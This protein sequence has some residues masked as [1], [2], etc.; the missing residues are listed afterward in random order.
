MQMR[1]YLEFLVPLFIL[2][3]LIFWFLTRPSYLAADQTSQLESG[4]PVAGEQVYWAGGCGSCHA[5]KGATGDEKLLLGGGHPLITPFGTFYTPNISPDKTHGIGAW[6][7]AQFA[8]AM[9]NGVSP[10]GKHYYPSFPYGSYTRMTLKDIADLWAYMKTLPAVANPNKDHDLPLLFTVRR[11]LGLW[12]LLFLDDQP[13]IPFEVDDEILNRGRY[14][15]EGVA[16][17]GECHTPRNLMGGFV[18]DRW[19]A[20][21]PAAEGQGKIPNITPHPDGIGDWSLTDIAYSLETGFTPDF[22]SF[23]SSMVSVQENMA[24]LTKSDRDAIAAYLKA[25]AP[26]ASETG[27][28]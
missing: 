24:K 23:G 14:L 17:C 19:M 28:N 15:V 6:T 12:K 20:G 18:Q 21:G 27:S 2:G 10:D 1:K 7:A 8:N 11:G 3:V 5:K 22:D 16:H 13:I 26:V 25:V 9:K 4:D